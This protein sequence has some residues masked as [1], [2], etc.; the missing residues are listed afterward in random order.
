[1]PGVTL[2]EMLVV[3]TVLAV[4]AALSAPDLMKRNED[5]SVV[6]MTR[7][8]EMARRDALRAGDEVSMVIRPDGF[9]IS[10][11]SPQNGVRLLREG[12]G[13]LP[14]FS[15]ARIAF[16]PAGTARADTVHMRAAR[17]VVDP[18]TGG[19]RVLGP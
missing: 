3:L 9:V 4:V 12:A 11:T 14:V 8:I 1:M 16:G 18:W 19:T 7:M 10:M 5:D 13:P 6:N 17:I 2:L 15:E